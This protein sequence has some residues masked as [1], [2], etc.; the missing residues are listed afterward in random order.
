[1]KSLVAAVTAIVSSSFEER[2]VIGVADA[3]ASVE[4]ATAHAP[5]QGGGLS[6]ATKHHKLLEWGGGGVERYETESKGEHASTKEKEEKT[7]CGK[8]TRPHVGIPTAALLF[9]AP[10][11][12]TQ[13]IYTA[14]SLLAP[15][16]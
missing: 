15:F 6:G 2:Y 5:I 12:T 16:T 10:T 4:A 11:I 3:S 8:R 9:I 1:L 14:L 13:P 7:G